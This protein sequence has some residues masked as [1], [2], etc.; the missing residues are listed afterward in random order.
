MSRPGQPRERDFCV[1]G[2]NNSWRLAW[3][4]LLLSGGLSLVIWSFFVSNIICWVWAKSFSTVPAFPFWGSGGWVALGCLGAPNVLPNKPLWS[5]K[6]HVGCHA[7]VLMQ[8]R[9]VK[10]GPKWPFNRIKICYSTRL[11]ILGVLNQGVHGYQIQHSHSHVCHPSILFRLGQDWIW[12][13]LYKLRGKH[14]AHRY[15]LRW[16][17]NG[18]Y[19][20]TDLLNKYFGSETSDSC[21]S[22]LSRV[23]FIKSWVCGASQTA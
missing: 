6:D 15:I 8:D 10:S 17:L 9:F 2:V 21:S 23:R 11:E 7:H 14:E 5:S 1:Q 22:S 20:V 4:R 3:D 16:W 12:L 18:I 19:L 13:K